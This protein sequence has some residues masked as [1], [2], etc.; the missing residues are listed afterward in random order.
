MVS[1]PVAVLRTE[2]DQASP[3]LNRIVAGT[4]AAIVEEAEP[5]VQ[6]S[7]AGDLKGWL[8]VTDLRSLETLPQDADDR[9]QQM[10]LD[11]ALFKGVP[12]V[13]GGCSGLGID[14]SG[15]VQLLHRLVGVE[16]PRDADMQFAD[17]RPVDP[18]F[19]PG[20][21]LFFYGSGKRRSITHV[22]MSVGGWQMLHSSIARN[23]VYEDNVQ[24]VDHLRDRFAGARSF[25]D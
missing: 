5:W 8:S 23:G 16:T 17:G 7:L 15:L 20:D 21:L 12:Y 9:R 11:G 1:T 14:C 25:L 2:P 19:R 22:G 13:W 24:T 3:L 6:V 18:P 4:T 10:M